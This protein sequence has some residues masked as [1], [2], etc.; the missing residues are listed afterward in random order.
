MNR[1]PC[2]RL[3]V[4]MVRPSIAGLPYLAHF[5][6]KCLRILGVVV[7]FAIMR[8]PVHELALSARPA[9]FG[10]TISAK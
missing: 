5:T 9:Q 10:D 2:A 1:R 7:P 6:I 3:N 4:C 8:D